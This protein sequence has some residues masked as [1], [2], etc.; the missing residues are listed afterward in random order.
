MLI[1]ETRLLASVMPKEHITCTHTI[2]ILENQ[3]QSGHSCHS[4]VRI[5]TTSKWRT[6]VDSPANAQVPYFTLVGQPKESVSSNL[7]FDV[8]RSLYDSYNKVGNKNTKTNNA[9]QRPDRAAR[10]KFFHNHTSQRTTLFS[11]LQHIDQNLPGSDL[12]EVAMLLRTHLRTSGLESFSMSSRRTSVMGQYS[13][14]SWN[15]RR[16]HTACTRTTGI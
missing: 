5:W 2:L 7:L 1:L 3:F 11:E 16:A 9:T 4:D 8:S 13:S 10:N 14:G 12:S 15:S 6:H